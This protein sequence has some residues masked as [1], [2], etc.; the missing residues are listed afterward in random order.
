VTVSKKGPQKNGEGRNEESKTE[1][2]VASQG[3]PECL[4]GVLYTHQMQTG[5]GKVRQRRGEA[6]TAGNLERRR[7]K[8]FVSRGKK[9]K[10]VVHSEREKERT[11]SRRTL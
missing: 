7:R 5:G 6:E 4:K 3:R 2:K 8:Q 1:R 11:L 10:L 9:K